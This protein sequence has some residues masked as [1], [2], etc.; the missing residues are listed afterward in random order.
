MSETTAP[1]GKWANSALLEA[2]VMGFHGVAKEGL[3]KDTKEAIIEKVHLWGFT[4]IT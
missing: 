2:L 4:D 1:T 3:N